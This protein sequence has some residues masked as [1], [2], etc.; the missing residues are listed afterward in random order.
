MWAVLILDGVSSPLI[1]VLPSCLQYCCP[2]R[3]FCSR[4]V[5]LPQGHGMGYKSLPELMF[6]MSV[7]LRCRVLLSVPELVASRS[8]R[9]SCL[10]YCCLIRNLLLPDECAPSVCGTVVPCGTYV[11]DRVYSLAGQWCP[12]LLSLP[13]LLDSRSVCRD[14]NWLLN[15]VG[16]C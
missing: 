9:P 15:G 14:L 1:S 16:W 3:N 5:Y 12:V 13:E 6:P 11:P 8:V 2:F 7:P 10:G 4:S